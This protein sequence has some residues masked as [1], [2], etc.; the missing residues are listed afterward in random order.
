MG[1]WENGKCKVTS[2]KCKVKS[3]VDGRRPSQHEGSRTGRRLF[4]WVRRATITRAGTPAHRALPGRQP[5]TPLSTLHFSLVT[6]HF[7]FSHSPILPFSHS[8]TPPLPHSPIPPL[9]HSRERGRVLT[10]AVLLLA[11]AAVAFPFYWMLISSLKTASE[12]TQI[13]PTLFPHAPTL[14]NYPEVWRAEPFA[15]YFANTVGVAGSVTLGVLITSSLAAHAFARM[16]FLGSRLLFIALLATLMIP[17]EVILIPDYLIVTQLHWDDTYLALI[18]PWIANVFGIFLLRQFFL[19]I[20]TEL[21]EA[22]LLDG[23]GHL[24]YLFRVAIPLARPGLSVVAIVTFLGSWNALLWP[25]VVITRRP[26]L[27][28]IQVGMQ[29]FATGE[30]GS[31]L[32]LA[33][34]AAT[35]TI[36]PVVI[37]FLIAQRQFVE[38]IARTGVKG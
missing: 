37:L 12:A 24:A 6:L 5:S 22:A 19:G 30:F 27:R 20:P 25:L 3:G 10:H 2:E 17:F 26:E 18:V 38:S 31:Y 21:W 35:I 4:G 15:R 28:P 13:P 36:L 34:T 32:H 33:M 23:C 9:P 16:R 7:P 1:E 29:S 14:A 11:G 8:P